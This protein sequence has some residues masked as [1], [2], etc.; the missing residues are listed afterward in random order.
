MGA[1]AGSIG[2]R[3]RGNGRQRRDPSGRGAIAW[4]HRGCAG[5]AEVEIRVPLVRTAREWLPVMQGCRSPRRVT[6]IEKTHHA[7]IL[8]IRGS[9]MAFPLELRASRRA[10]V[11]DAPVLRC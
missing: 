9:G 2:R 6:Y 7:A 10:S 4:T 8:A 1:R 11:Y 3:C 5:A